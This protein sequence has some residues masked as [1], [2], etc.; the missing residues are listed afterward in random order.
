[1]ICPKC[2]SRA[3]GRI[4]LNQYYCW[5]CN[6]EFVPTKDGF[7]MYRLEDD[8]TALLDSLEQGTEVN[9]LQEIQDDENITGRNGS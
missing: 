1:M 6:I 4:G 8:G 9:V 3:T 7:R 2:K 5:D